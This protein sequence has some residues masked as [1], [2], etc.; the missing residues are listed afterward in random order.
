MPDS[1]VDLD[2]R[3][4]QDPTQSVPVP[5]EK[6]YKYDDR[7]GLSDSQESSPHPARISDVIPPLGALDICTPIL[8][9]V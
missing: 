3:V 7:D 9:C 8:V 6:V 4:S 2:N 5:P 1:S